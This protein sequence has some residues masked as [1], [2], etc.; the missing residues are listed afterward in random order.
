MLVFVTW[1]VMMVATMILAACPVILLS[2]EI[3]RR[4]NERQGTI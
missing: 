1:A 3:N 4:R 2:A